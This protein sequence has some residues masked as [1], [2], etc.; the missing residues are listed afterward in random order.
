MLG[1]LL[2]AHLF[3]G[4]LPQG[5]H[6]VVL[7]RFPRPGTGVLVDFLH[8]GDLL[9]HPAVHAAGV[10]LIQAEN[11]P[12]GH[13]TLGHHMVGSVFFHGES[14]LS[15]E[16]SCFPVAPFLRGPPGKMPA[17]TFAK[18]VP[19]LGNAGSRLAQSKLGLHSTFL[20]SAHRWSRS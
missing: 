4:Q 19:A 12:H 14:L 7:Q 16:P 1:E 17:A 20:P 15:R 5:H 10:S 3:Q 6:R 11:L 9:H 2:P 8:Q 18:A 13:G